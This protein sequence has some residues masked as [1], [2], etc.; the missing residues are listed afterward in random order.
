MTAQTDDRAEFDFEIDFSNGGGIQ[1]QGFR[2]DIDGGDISDE[3]LAAYVVSDL[4]LLM[5]ASVRILHKR[6]IREPHKRAA[7]RAP[8]AATDGRSRIDLS[9]DVE[10]GVITYRGL[11]VP[12]VCD[13]LSH[14]PKRST[15][16]E[17]SSRSARYVC[18][19]TQAPTSTAR[20][21]AIATAPIFRSCR[22]SASWTSTPYVRM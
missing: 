12:V 8:P 17:P 7:H 1:G 4:R 3:D 21:T 15:R 5:L 13:F 14:E 19:P 2:L 11:P 16:P 20:F 10:D 6:I 18:A 9:H 22:S